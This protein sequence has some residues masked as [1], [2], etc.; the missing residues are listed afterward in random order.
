MKAKL[1][2]IEPESSRGEIKL[3]VP[4][5]I[6]RGDEAKLKLVHPLVS[7]LHCEIYEVDDQLMV[8]DLA[9]LNGTFVNQE[10][11]EDEMA[12]PS[13][14]ILQVGSVKFQVLYGEDFDRAPSPP[15]AKAASAAS[16][17]RKAAEKTSQLGDE[18]NLDELWGLSDDNSA[19]GETLDLDSLVDEPPEKP[20]PAKGKQAPA[21]PAAAKPAAASKPAAA[22][23]DDELKLSPK[24]APAAK[25]SGKADKDAPED[26]GLDDFLESIL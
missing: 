22:D 12:L 8:R 9:S 19:V 1:V 15:A 16:P 7:R 11:I 25:P 18:E 6:G 23:D 24:S 20:T 21:K 4:A 10:R 2:L 14:A 5:K 26:D 13:R 17:V 3:S